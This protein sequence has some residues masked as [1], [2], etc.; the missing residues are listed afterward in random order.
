MLFCCALYLLQQDGDSNPQGTWIGYSVLG[1][2]YEPNRHRDRECHARSTYHIGFCV[3]TDIDITEVSIEELEA[4]F[5]KYTQIQIWFVP[6]HHTSH[7]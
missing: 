4:S 7:C 1:C 3:E 6:H 2:H 5:S